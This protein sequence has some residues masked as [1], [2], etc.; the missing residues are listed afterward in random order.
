MLTID[1]KAVETLGMEAL[2]EHHPDAV[3][4]IQQKINN[5]KV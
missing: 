1:E 4:K 5:R 2:I 3:I